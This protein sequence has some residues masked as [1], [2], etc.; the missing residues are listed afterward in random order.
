[1]I[2]GRFGDEDELVFDVDLIAR[3]EFELPVNAILDTGFSDF[4]VLA[5]FR[6]TAYVRFSNYSAFGHH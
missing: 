1:M 4:S 3:D 6:Y 5:S 2:L